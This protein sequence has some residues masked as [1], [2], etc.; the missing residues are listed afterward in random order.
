MKKRQAQR[1]KEPP[2]RVPLFASP[3]VALFLLI[4]SEWLPPRSQ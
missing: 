1:K 4:R 3:W 2:K